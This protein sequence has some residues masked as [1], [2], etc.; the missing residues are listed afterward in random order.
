[1]VSMSEQTTA[2]KGEGVVAVIERHA[3]YLM[4]QRAARVRAGGFWCFVGGAIEEGETQAQA[5]VREVREELGLDV[6]PIEKVWECLSYN[7]EWLLHCWSAR[8]LGDR[9]SINRQEVADARWM[10]V[11]RIT[12]LPQVLPSVIEYF[13]FRSLL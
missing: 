2:V 8:P 13:R 7:G 6:E 11:P 5:L 1:M 3:R 9:L 10:T 4:I 12:A